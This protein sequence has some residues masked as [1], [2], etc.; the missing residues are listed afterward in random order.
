[1]GRNGNELYGN[2]REWEYE[3]PF[4]VISNYVEYNG[5]VTFC[6]NEPY[7]DSVMTKL[8]FCNG[9]L[10]IFAVLYLQPQCHPYRV[11]INCAVFYINLQYVFNI[12]AK[13]F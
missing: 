1:M 5:F 6:Q 8:E 12:F 7:T 4:P 2:G 3:K 9:D 13:M 10:L 11:C